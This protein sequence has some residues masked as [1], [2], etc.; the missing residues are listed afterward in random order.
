MSFLQSF[1][2]CP[3]LLRPNYG[4]QHALVGCRVR[5]AVDRPVPVNHQEEEEEV[6]LRLFGLGSIMN[7]DSECKDAR[8]KGSLTAWRSE[9]VL[10]ILLLVLLF[11]VTML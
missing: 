8:L 9:N 6:T 7:A 11:V 10:F 1:R 5:V 3:V 4:Q 2:V